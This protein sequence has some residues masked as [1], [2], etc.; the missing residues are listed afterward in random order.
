MS[1]YYNELIRLSCKAA[2]NNCVPV[3]AIIIYKDKIISKA[4]NL[5]DKTNNVLDHAEVIAIKKAAKRL[6]TWNLSECEL[7]VTMKPCNMCA[8][9]INEARIKKI[10]YILENK[11]YENIK[12]NDNDRIEY[13][14]EED[15]NDDY[16]NI[17]KDFFKNLRK[18]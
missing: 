11:K 10:H 12:I 9:I 18:K 16:K 14:I 1:V 17:L 4:Y 6:K 8:S 3:S 15:E 5:R 2:N 7:Y 13:I